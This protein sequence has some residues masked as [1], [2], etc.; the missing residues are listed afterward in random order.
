[1]H[2][3]G[4]AMARLEFDTIRYNEKGNSVLLIR[5]FSKHP[6]MKNV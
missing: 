4:I 2:G 6:S 1:M 5:T 3:R